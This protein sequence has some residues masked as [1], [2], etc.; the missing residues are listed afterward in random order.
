MKD[1]VLEQGVLALGDLKNKIMKQ[2]TLTLITAGL[3]AASASASTISYTTTG[4]TLNC[5]AVVGCTQNNSTQV[6]IGGLTL[7]YNSGAGNNVV[8]TSNINFGNIQSTGTGSSVNLAGLT[9]VISINSTPQGQGTTSG[10]MQ[11]GNLSGQLSTNSSS[12]NITWSSN[13]TTTSV[14]TLPG[15][16]IGGQVYQVL[17]PTLGLQAPTIGTP[18]GQTSIQGS[19]SDV[20]T[21]EPATLALMGSGLALAG[22]LR[23]RAVGQLA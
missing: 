23:R 16:V 13:N 14:G 6:T 5:N 4:T 10:T 15:V 21:P 18:I 1:S 22:L 7:T 3:M 17:N 9:L 20:T 8:T 12:A 11:D 2:L 19:V